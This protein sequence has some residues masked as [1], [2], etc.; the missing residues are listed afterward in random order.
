MNYVKTPEGNEALRQRHALSLRE[1]Q[2]MVLCNG[3]R[4]LDD[5]IDLFG[6]SV[7]TEVQQ[8]QHRGLLA[9]LAHARHLPPGAGGVPPTRFVASDLPPD[10]PPA[11]NPA[12]LARLS[13]QE[14]AELANVPPLPGTASGADHAASQPTPPRES[15]STTVDVPADAPMGAPTGAQT[16]AQT[17]AQTALATAVNRI[18]TGQMPGQSTVAAQ[19]YMTQVL[20]ALEDASATALIESHGDVRHDVDIVLYLAQGLGLAHALAGEDVA[21]RVALRT[22]GLLPADA[23]PMLLDCALDHVPACF[24]LLLYEFALAGRDTSR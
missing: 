15:G 4:T 14:L 5:L 24:G 11:P 20:M 21:L 22:S 10:A 17:G 18:D 9:T 13:L 19:A 3:V 7:A 23:V 6:S 16:I 2:I 1:R 12:Q 8:L